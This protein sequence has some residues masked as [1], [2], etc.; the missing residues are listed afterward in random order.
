MTFDWSSFVDEK[1]EDGPAAAV[2]EKSLPFVPDGTHVGEIK[3]AGYQQKDWAKKPQNPDG[4][5]LTVKIAVPGYKPVWESIPCHFFGKVCALCAA[6]SVNPPSKQS[7]NW[8]ESQLVGRMVTIETLLGVSKA[9]NEYVKV[10]RLKP[11]PKPLPPQ[12]ASAPPRKPPKAAKP[13]SEMPL[14][15]IPF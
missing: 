10:E 14:D 8:D 2:D 12:V 1:Q 6:A 13:A 9:G 3:W 15:D 11:G 4:D 7:P 5:C